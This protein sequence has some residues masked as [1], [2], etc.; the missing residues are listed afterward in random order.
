MELK[1][2]MRN[3]IVKVFAGS[4]AEE[5]EIEP[6]DVLLKV[7]GMPISDVLDY[8]YLTSDEYVTLEIE[9]K[10][11]EV[12]SLEIEKDFDENI[13]IEFEEQLMD[14][15]KRCCN[16]CVFCFIDQLPRGMRKTLYFKDDDFRLSF[17]QGNFVTLTNLNDKDLD[18]II[19][20]RISPINISVHTT[21]PELRIKMLNN[22]NA[23][24]ICDKIKKLCEAGI[25][26]NCQIVL[27]R[28]LNDGAELKRTL[29]DLF[30]FY[31]NIQNVAVVPVGV[32]RFRENLFPVQTFDKDSAFELINAVNGYTSYYEKKSGIPFVRLSD[33]FYVI[34]GASIPQASFYGD[35]SQ[36]EDGVG[37]IR[38][39]RDT[40]EK[41]I[42]DLRNEGRVELIFATGLSAYNELLNAAQKIMQHNSEIKIN[43]I[44]IVN[45]YFGKDI[46]V[47]GLIT[48][49]DI[50]EQVKDIKGDTVFIPDTMLRKGYEI[51]S[52]EN[53]VFLDNYSIKDL[54]NM[55]LKKIVICSFTGEDL[56]DNVNKFLKED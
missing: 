14:N 10:N 22:K 8:K 31:P 48:A 33:E 34:A 1:K 32:T 49:Q 40:V 42:K 9:K 55:L 56:I 21:N 28:S 12:W 13:G 4:I 45:N 2:H 5:L 41:N 30:E 44:K 18:R 36:I 43:V 15:P 11:G 37:I 23:G 26:I 7:N 52:D 27:C 38:T 35:F 51:C 6:D 47:A 50:Y 25:S 17:L 24:S 39:F 53:N 19:R 16:K 29:D 3:K 46:T 54:G 20:Y